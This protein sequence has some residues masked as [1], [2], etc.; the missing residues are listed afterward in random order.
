[1]NIT[2]EER[3]ALERLRRAERDGHLEGAYGSISMT[4]SWTMMRNADRKTAAAI[5]LRL[6]REDD[7]EAITEEWLRSVGFKEGRFKH[8][9]VLSPILRGINTAQGLVYWCVRTYQIPDEAVPT[10]SGQLRRLASCLGIEL[11]EPS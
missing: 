2:P 6:V 7:E 4:D 11:K 1:M 9:L 5:A 10:T 3:A 8:D